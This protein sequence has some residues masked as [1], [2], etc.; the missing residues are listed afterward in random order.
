VRNVNTLQLYKVCEFNSGIVIIGSRDNLQ[1][2]DT[3]ELI[4]ADL[5]TIGEY[6]ARYCYERANGK[7]P[8]AAHAEALKGARVIAKGH[9]DQVTP[10]VG[11]G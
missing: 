7:D 2:P 6:L 1:R 5:P 11:H 3:V 4:I 10:E 8:K 9:L